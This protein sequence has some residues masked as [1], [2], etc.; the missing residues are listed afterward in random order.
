MLRI[1]LENGDHSAGGVL[2]GM[3]I[4]CDIGVVDESFEY[5]LESFL[6]V[7]IG[8]DESMVSLA[9]MLKSIVLISSQKHGEPVLPWPVLKTG[10]RSVC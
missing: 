5:A 9:M 8:K 4:D 3:I 10:D 1:C 2:L 7:G 6:L